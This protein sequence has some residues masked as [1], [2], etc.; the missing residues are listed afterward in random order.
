METRLCVVS[1]LRFP[2]F[3]SSHPFFLSFFLSLRPFLAFVT[4]RRDSFKA[5][6]SRKGE[7]GIAR[8]ELPDRVGVRDEN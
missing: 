5:A 3:F 8:Q 2:F 6:I 1:G 4:V 7:R